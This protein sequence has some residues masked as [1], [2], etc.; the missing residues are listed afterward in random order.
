MIKITEGDLLKADVEALVNTVN[1]VG[2]MGRGIA[3][4]FKLKYPEN[5]KHYAK[6]CKRGELRPGKLF[7]FDRGRLLKTG[8]APPDGPRFIINFPTK[9][10]W[11]EKS[12]LSYIRDGMAALVDEVH[13]RGI[14][15]IAIPPLGCGNGGLDWKEVRTII[16]S[17]M[18]EGAPNVKVLL[19]PPR[20]APDVRRRAVNTPPPNMT[21]VRALCI[22]LLDLYRSPTYRLS[23]LEVQKLAY[24][25]QCAGEDLQLDYVPHKYGPYAGVLNHVMQGL[26]GHFIQGYGD[27]D[28]RSEIALLPGAVEQAKDVTRDDS[29]A[30]AHLE[31]VARLIDGFETPYGMELLTTVLWLAQ[32]D[33]TVQRSARRAIERAHSWNR[34]KREVLRPKHLQVAWQ[35]LASQN[36]LPAAHV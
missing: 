7:I 26:E 20:G 1:C 15:S 12:R 2:V 9:R 11:R 21:R 13:A 29:E 34:R 30:E 23:R 35:R 17:A 14:R 33:P 25:L 32:E 6:A 4:Q 24:L 3:L 5:F 10:H 19:Y 28:Q 36:W 27:R 18:E 31:R 16:E 22:R 8:G